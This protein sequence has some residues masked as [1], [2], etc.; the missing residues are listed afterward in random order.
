[1]VISTN[2]TQMLNG[3]YLTCGCVSKSIMMPLIFTKYFELTWSMVHILKQICVQSNNH[4][5]TDS[6]PEWICTEK[7]F[8]LYPY[9][10]NTMAKI[11]GTGQRGST[12]P[13]TTA[14]KTTIKLNQH[15]LKT[16]KAKDV[17][18]ISLLFAYL[19]N[20]EAVVWHKEV[21]GVPYIELITHF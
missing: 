7:F 19:A 15:L 3:E 8:E 12:G 20:S 18:V 16:L 17:L 6:L 21:V 9:D 13:K 2:K 4:K 14:S 11:L 1:M 5:L 10:I